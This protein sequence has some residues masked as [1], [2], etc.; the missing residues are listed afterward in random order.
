MVV[1][2]LWG[3]NI[4]VVYPFVQVVFNK[5]SMHDWVDVQIVKARSTSQ[6][7]ELSLRELQSPTGPTSRNVAIAKTP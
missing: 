4:T 5:Q 1:G 2:V 3:A 6:E 7:L